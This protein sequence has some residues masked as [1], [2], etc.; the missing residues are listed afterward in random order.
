[1]P[2][3]E[4]I[5]QTWAASAPELRARALSRLLQPL[6]P[7]SLV[8]VASGAFARFLERQPWL[9]LALTSEDIAAFRGD[10]VQELSQFVQQIQPVVLNDAWQLLSQGVAV[11]LGS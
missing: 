7:L 9:G 1:M 5:G 6:R 3:A 11:W 4:R 2:L 10:Q 8:A